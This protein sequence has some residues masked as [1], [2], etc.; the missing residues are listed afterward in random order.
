VI[1]SLATNRCVP[2]SVLDVTGAVYVDADA[3][4][5]FDSAHGYA[6]RLVAAAG[7]PTDPAA[8]ATQL[9][10]YDE[11]TAAQAASI[12]RTRDPAGF[13]TTCRHLIDTGPPVVSRG[14]DAYLKQWQQSTAADTGTAKP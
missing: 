10:A 7:E 11:A 5:R 2:V 9:A 8:L 14:V 13:E 12:L 3:S 1:V 4:G 6:T